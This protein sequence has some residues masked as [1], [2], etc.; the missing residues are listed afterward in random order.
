MNYEYGSI[1]YL[2]A[3]NDEYRF[4]LEQI[5]INIEMQKSGALSASQTLKSITHLIDSHVEIKPREE[6]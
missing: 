1:E 4:I 5:R 2:R 6:V 3:V